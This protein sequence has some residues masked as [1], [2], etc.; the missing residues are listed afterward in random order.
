MDEEETKRKADEETK[1]KK[2]E[3][4]N[5]NSGEGDKPKTVGLVEGANVAAERLETAN[6]KQEELLDRQEELMAKQALGGRTEAGQQQEEKE[7]T[8]KE[9]NNRIDKEI[10]EGQHGD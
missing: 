5:G 6:K 10:S 1:K 3:D 4:A 9:Y 7:E 8:P 2:Q